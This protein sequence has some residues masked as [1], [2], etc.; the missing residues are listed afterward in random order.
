LDR[1]NSERHPDVRHINKRPE[2]LKEDFLAALQ[3]YIS[4]KVMPESN[5]YLL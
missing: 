5:Q 4:L 3:N 1:Y 2:E